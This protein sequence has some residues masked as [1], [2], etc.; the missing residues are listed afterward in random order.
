MIPQRAA[1]ICELLR[2]PGSTGVQKYT[3]RILVG[4]AAHDILWPSQ[5]FRALFPVDELLAPL[6]AA[7]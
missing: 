6:L 4:R 3:V 7:R 5:G 2:M 1:G